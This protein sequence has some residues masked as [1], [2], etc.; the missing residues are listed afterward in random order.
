MPFT[1]YMESMCST[2]NSCVAKTAT[3]R[4]SLRRFWAAERRSRSPTP[5]RCSQSVAIR[6]YPDCFSA[7]LSEVGWS[8]MIQLRTC[9]QCAIL[10]FA[11]V[12]TDIDGTISR[13]RALAMVNRLREDLNANV[14]KDWD[15]AFQ[16]QMHRTDEEA[17]NQGLAVSW[18]SHGAF[19]DSVTRAVKDVYAWLG[20]SALLI[21]VL[22]VLMCFAENSYKSKP[23]LG[24]TIGFVSLICAFGGFSIQFA[25]AG[26]FNSFVYPVLFIVAGKYLQFSLNILLSIL[27]E[28]FCVESQSIFSSCPFSHSTPVKSANFSLT[29]LLRSAYDTRN[30][31]S[32]WQQK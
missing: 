12:E 19:I 7:R 5:R 26:D 3:D 10:A 8:L 4:T 11:G 30:G 17:S 28:A 27:F 24:L 14:L 29:R 16:E 9:H 23:I 20:L 32:K 1:L 25:S 31:T 18:W 21:V 2:G 22:C 6:T 13:A 15:H